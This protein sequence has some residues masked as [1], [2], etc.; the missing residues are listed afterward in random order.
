MITYTKVFDNS[1]ITVPV[2]H[3]VYHREVLYYY[4]I[5][6]WCKDNCR[7]P[8]YFAPGWQPES[9]VEFEDDRDAVL[10]ALKWS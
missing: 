1:D 5:R 6:S 7:A 2:L 3:T 4:D 8:F 9:F 10:F